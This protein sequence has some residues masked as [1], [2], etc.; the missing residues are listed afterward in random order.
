[1]KQ[2]RL[3]YFATS[4]NSKI[5]EYRFWRQDHASL[6][7]INIAVEEP[8]T[9]STDILIR[10]KVNAIKT[11]LPGLPFLVEQT[12]S[13]FNAT[14]ALQLPGPLTD[15]F[16]GLLGMKGT[17]E[18]LNGFSDRTA[19]V[20]TDLAFHDTDGGIHIYQAVMGDR[21]AEEQ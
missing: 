12:I 10:R 1:M 14:K 18:F 16:L 3:I 7:W 20:R 11:H 4:S 6:Q 15:R 19:L 9:L 13:I 2:K 8:L 21:I 17:C 5:S